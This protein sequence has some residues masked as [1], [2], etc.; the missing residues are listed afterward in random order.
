MLWPG[1]L[2]SDSHINTASHASDWAVRVSCCHRVWWCHTSNCHTARTRGRGGVNDNIRWR[3]LVCHMPD[4]LTGLYY[5]WG[6]CIGRNRSAHCWNYPQGIKKKKKCSLLRVMPVRNGLALGLMWLPC[7]TDGPVSSAPTAWRRACRPTWTLRASRGWAL[8]CQCRTRVSSS[9]APSNGI[10]R[11]R[12]QLASTRN[13][14]APCIRRDSGLIERYVWPFNH[15]I[16]Q[17]VNGTCVS[18]LLS[19]QGTLYMRKKTNH[20]T[21]SQIIRIKTTCDPS[22]FSWMDARHGRCWKS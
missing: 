12:S 16:S 10:H 13:A 8:P 17:S 22:L 1:S 2:R 11:N 14:T 15:N 5:E 20:S 21:P 7:D 18:Q 6:S 3:A 9:V 4:D 19:S